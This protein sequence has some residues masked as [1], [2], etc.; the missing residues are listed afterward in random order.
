VSARGVHGVTGPVGPAY[1]PAWPKLVERVRPSIVRVRGGGPGAG[2]VMWRTGTVLTNRHVLGD[3]APVVRVTCADGRDCAARVLAASPEL[4]LAGLLGVAGD[5]LPP[6]PIGA[7][8]ALRVGELVFAVGHPSGQP[9]VV[10]VGIVSGL[11]PVRLPPQAERP[12]ASVR[13]SSWHPAT[14]GGRS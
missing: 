2:G 13:T 9:W 4:D 11:S 10:T 7:S 6:A 8:A 1:P 14:R 3:G 12:P 5:D